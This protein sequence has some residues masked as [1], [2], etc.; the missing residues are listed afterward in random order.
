MFT[1]QE[2]IVGQGTCIVPTLAREGERDTM[3]I[4]INENKIYGN[5]FV[6]T[7]FVES[8]KTP[9]DAILTNK[10]SDGILVKPDFFD[11]SV[12]NY[13]KKYLSKKWLENHLKCKKRKIN[14]TRIFNCI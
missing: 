4:F 12:I 2:M 5:D 7:M 10:N 1:K 9:N 3:I 6:E 8:Q 11:K 14:Y 13:S